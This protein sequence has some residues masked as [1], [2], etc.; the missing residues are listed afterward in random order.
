MSSSL[1]VSNSLLHLCLPRFESVFLVLCIYFFLV[2]LILYYIYF[3]LAP[4]VYII[5]SLFVCILVKC[6]LSAVRLTHSHVSLACLSCRAL[7][8]VSLF[9]ACVVCL[10]L[11]SCGSVFYLVVISLNSSFTPAFHDSLWATRCMGPSLILVFPSLVLCQ[12]FNS[13]FPLSLCCFYA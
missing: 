2:C 1:C 10:V 5:L 3:F 12:S 9:G 13:P 7:S 11:I 6:L 8:F 4:C